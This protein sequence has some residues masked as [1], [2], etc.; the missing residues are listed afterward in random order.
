M[1]GVRVLVVELHPL[2]ADITCDIILGDPSLAFVG[3]A[4]DVREATRLVARRRPDV[5]LV[6]VALAGGSGIELT[7]RVTFL[8]P[9]LPVILVG[10]E[11]NGEYAEEAARAGAAGY[12]SWRHVHHELLS[13]IHRVA[14]P[15]GTLGKALG[16]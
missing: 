5:V 12:L 7:R 4:R 3:E 8:S 6:D 15:K 11:S 10:E 16:S 1:N 13:L 14:P 9:G 2:L